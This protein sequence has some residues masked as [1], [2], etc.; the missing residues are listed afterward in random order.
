LNTPKVLDLGPGTNPAR[1]ATTDA[2]TLESVERH[3]IEEALRKAGWRI[4]GAG[5]AAEQLGL[6]PNTLRFR[7]KKLKITRP[8]SVGARIRP[9]TG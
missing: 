9:E 6:H 7:M 8:A 1:V 2:G 3:H 5:N 4:N